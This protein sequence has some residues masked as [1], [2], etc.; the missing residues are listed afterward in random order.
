M[1]LPL[2]KADCLII[3]EPYDAPAKTGDFCRIVKFE[4]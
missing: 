4:R 2:A 3:R 1:M